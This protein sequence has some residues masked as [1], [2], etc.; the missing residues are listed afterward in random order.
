[1][2]KSIL[3]TDS[4]DG[5]F[6]YSGLILF[7]SASYQR[8]IRILFNNVVNIFYCAI[9]RTVVFQLD[10]AHGSCKLA[11]LGRGGSL[12]TLVEIACRIGVAASGSIHHLMRSIGWNLVERIV[13]INQRTLASQGDD[14]LGNA[15]GMNQLGGFYRVFQSGDGF[16]LRLVHLQIIGVLEHI[17]LI[18]PV[19]GIDFLVSYLAQ[20][21]LHIDGNLTLA[22]KISN[23]FWREIIAQQTA[24]MINLSLYMLQ[25]SDGERVSLGKYTLLALVLVFF[26][27]VFSEN[28]AKIC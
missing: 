27:D 21:A 28:Y 16:H 12:Q 22:G 18:L 20:I 6:V 1:M 10:G 7:L 25:L 13:Y 9:E 14:Y 23:Y 2:K 24:Q 4:Q 17:E 3:R 19:D 5:S 15:P 11:S 26:V 8:L